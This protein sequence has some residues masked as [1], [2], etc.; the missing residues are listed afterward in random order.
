MTIDEAKDLIIKNYDKYFNKTI[1][2]AETGER[3]VVKAIDVTKD[4]NGD[5]DATCYTENANEEDANFE[6]GIFEHRSLTSVI[7]QGKLI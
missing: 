2:F 4:D 1:Y 5:Y 6:N 7:T 3:L